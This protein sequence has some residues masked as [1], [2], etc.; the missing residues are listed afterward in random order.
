MRSVVGSDLNSFVFRTTLFKWSPII[1]YN[2]LPSKEFTFVRGSVSIDLFENVII[3]SFLDGKIYLIVQLT[4][5][6]EA[7]VHVLS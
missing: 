4:Q 5:N 3:L 2:Q 6:F 7:Q 1:G